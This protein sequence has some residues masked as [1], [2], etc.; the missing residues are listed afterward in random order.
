MPAT[1][2]ESILIGAVDWTTSAHRLRP[3]REAVFV[4]EQGIP[5]ELEWDSGDADAIHLLAC[6]GDGTPVGVIRM[7]PDGRIGRMAVLREWRGRGIGGRL[8]RAMLDHAAAAGF[9][10]VHLHAQ[11]AAVRFYARRGFT[12]VGAP[13]GEAGIPH[14]A[15]EY[16]FMQED[17]HKS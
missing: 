8:L 17:A 3:V 9:A 14:Q 13:F 12:P 5:A 16:V 7:Q 6:A 10:R 2:P 15:M 11:S 4:Q 1:D